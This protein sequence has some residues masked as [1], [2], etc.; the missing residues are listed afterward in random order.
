MSPNVAPTGIEKLDKSLGGGFPR[1]G[2]TLIVGPTGIGKTILSLQ[3]LAQG[4]RHGENTIYISTTVPV[5]RI[6]HYYGNMPFLS[7]VKDKIRWYDLIIEPKDMLP[8]T[9]EKEHRMFHNIMP[10]VVDEKLNL[11]IPVHRGVVD[12]ITSIERIIGDPAMFR[13]VSSRWIKFFISKKISVVLIEE[14]RMKSDEEW[15]E[16]RNFSEAT[17][18]MNYLQNQ[19]IYL[20]ALKIVKRYGYN[21]P[22]YWMPFHIRETGITL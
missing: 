12:S 4:A 10:D 16:M 22:T 1:D 2:V 18:A 15:G 11:N 17:I 20:R 3:W 6:K 13:Y 19:N 7:D 21:N 14:N 5:E 8:F 9:M